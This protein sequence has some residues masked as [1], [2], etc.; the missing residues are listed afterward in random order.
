MYLS[1]KRKVEKLFDTILKFFVWV[2]THFGVFGLVIVV[3]LFILVIL[4]I[5]FA[6]KPK[7]FETFKE[8][9]KI[10][11]AWKKRK[12]LKITKDKLKKHDIF[13]KKMKYEFDISRIDFRKEYYKTKIVQLA[14]NIK[15]DVDTRILK[16]FLY[17]EDLEKVHKLR[18]Q[19][20][21][22]N[23]V[24]DMVEEF[25]DV[26]KVKLRK[27]V[28]EQVSA[29][30]RKYTPEQMDIFADKIFHYFMYEEG[31]FDEERKKR[32]TDI[33]IDIENIPVSPLYNTNFERVYRFFEI[34]NRDNEKVISHAV[35]DYRELNGYFEKMFHNFIMEGKII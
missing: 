35:E 19:D 24:K 8:N 12:R 4:T 25:N 15:L 7:Q 34:I 3:I 23:C 28:E 27:F 16:H 26:F 20:M 31:G 11:K 2:L 21:M 13:R 9:W 5:V 14:N 6:V 30:N 32:L 1:Q 29:F 33:Y 10:W 22:G 18:L 17:N